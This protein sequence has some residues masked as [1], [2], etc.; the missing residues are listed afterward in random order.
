MLMNLNRLN[1]FSS[2]NKALIKFSILLYYYLF[3]F[4]TILAECPRKVEGNNHVGGQPPGLRPASHFIQT[5]F[6]FRDLEALDRDFSQ[7]VIFKLSE[8]RP[9]LRREALL[10]LDNENLDCGD[11]QFSIRC[12][13]YPLNKAFHYLIVEDSRTGAAVYSLS[14]ER[15]WEAVGR[16]RVEAEG[17]LEMA[18]LDALSRHSIHSLLEFGTENALPGF[19][20]EVGA[21]E[22]EQQMREN[23]KEK[24]KNKKE[25]QN[26]IELRSPFE[27]R[28]LNLK[29]LTERQPIFDDS[30][31]SLAVQG[32][33]FLKHFHGSELVEAIE[34]Q[35]DVENSPAVFV[36]FWGTEGSLGE[37]ALHLWKRSAY[38]WKNMINDKLNIKREAV[39]GVVKCDEEGIELCRAFGVLP[40]QKPQFL[41]FMD[42]QRVGQQ[43]G[44]GDEEFFIDWIRLI[45]MGSLIHI[46][47]V[48]TKNNLMEFGP[49]TMGIFRDEQQAEFKSYRRVAVLLAGRYQLAYKLDKRQ[50]KK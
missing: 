7:A 27:L 10:T 43:M 31:E 40:K 6:A 47:D 18:L 46:K 14:R 34:T 15:N 2:N 8:L 11:E 4:H 30:A 37:H 20:R 42:G 32:S 50:R 33:S 24:L 5:T 19:V 21:A 49:I 35:T 48:T 45:L 13:D 17:R 38:K 29:I 25:K 9:R 1:I 39:F 41:A 22:M 16:N 28:M 26:R 3:I 44:L 23:H 36:L 12:S